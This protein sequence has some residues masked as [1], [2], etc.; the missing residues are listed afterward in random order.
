MDVPQLREFFIKVKEGTSSVIIEVME[1][2]QQMIAKIIDIL[3]SEQNSEIAELVYS[4]LFP[5]YQ[6]GSDLEKAFVLHFVPALVWQYLFVSSNH[7]KMGYGK[8]E[9]VL[10]AIFNAEVVDENGKT[11]YQTFRLPSLSQPSVYH[12]PLIGK[13][14]AS[15]LTESALS[16][17]EQTKV[18][19]R[20][21]GPGHQLTRIPACHRFAVMA[22]VLEQ[23]NLYIA[24][25]GDASLEAAC[26]MA[27]RT[28]SCGFKYLCQENEHDENL[29]SLSKCSRI[30]LDNAALMQLVYIVYYAIFNG[31]SVPAQRAFQA[32]HF[33]AGHGL[34]TEAY[35]LTQSIEHLLQSRGEQGFDGPLGLTIQT[36]SPE[37]I[38]KQA[39]SSNQK[40]PRCLDTNNLPWKRRCPYEILLAEKSAP[41]K[42][43][44]DSTPLATSKG[45]EGQSRA[46]KDSRPKKS[47]SWVNLPGRASLVPSAKSPGPPP[48]SPLA[49]SVATD[50]SKVENIEMSK[51]GNIETS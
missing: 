26:K 37:P 27:L 20:V 15:A 43:E 24:F 13:S 44:L 9:A 45:A 22:L 17:H 33:R 5:L 1:N 19:Y 32:L 16:R 6:N 29:E 10:L 48:M 38:S 25:M 8:L 11:R 50:E 18:T 14:S 21:S 2:D 41:G 35:L 3:M 51:V 30:P 28:A 46:A 23:Y 49:V 36:T 4:N 42:L 47:R 7:E 34:F 40:L 12:E 31:F 39:D